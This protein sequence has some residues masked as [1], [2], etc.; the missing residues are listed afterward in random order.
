MLPTLQH[1]PPQEKTRSQNPLVCLRP[2]T[3]GQKKRFI[4]LLTKQVPARHQISTSTQ[5]LD[6]PLLPMAA[7]SRPCQLA[8]HHITCMSHTRL[9]PPSVANRHPRL[10]VTPSSRARRVRKMKG[11]TKA[12]S[13]HTET[14][15][16]REALER[17]RGMTLACSPGK[18]MTVDQQQES[19]MMTVEAH[20][21]LVAR[22]ASPSFSLWSN[23]CS[24]CT[25]LPTA[26]QTMSLASR[27]QGRMHLAPATPAIT[28]DHFTRAACNDLHW[29]TTGHGCYSTTDRDQ[30]HWA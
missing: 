3:R 5:S 11:P 29:A 20:C 9:L 1:F 23:P 21:L 2:L 30:N 24:V 7:R 18:Q 25:A 16:T 19:V 8:K 12:T 15:G 10:P 14:H 27:L 13:A 22:A 28:Q 17:V 26:Q 4:L 6:S